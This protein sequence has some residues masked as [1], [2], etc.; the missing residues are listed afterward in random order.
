LEKRARPEQLERLERLGIPE[1]PVQ[2]VQQELLAKRA[3]PEQLVL[4]DLL[5]Q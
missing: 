1:P 4:L 2:L 5:V 3:R